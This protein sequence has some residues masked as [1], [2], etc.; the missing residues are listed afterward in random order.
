MDWAMRDPAFKTQLFRFID[1]M[2]SLRTP[3]QIY[4]HLHEYLTQS[5]V[6]VPA[7]LKLGLTAGGLLKGTLARTVVSQIESM[8]AAFVAAED[9]SRPPPDSQK[10]LGPQH[11][12]QRR[13]IG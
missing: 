12:L 4:Q 10:P 1:V 7:F 8:A 2:P 9:L 3:D 5:G 13:F 11:C 6:Q